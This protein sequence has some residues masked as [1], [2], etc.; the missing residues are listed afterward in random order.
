MG[1][2]REG[3][4]VTGERSRA[5]GMEWPKETLLERATILKTQLHEAGQLSARR[6]PAVQAAWGQLLCA[7]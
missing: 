3:G 2:G 1:V 4:I 6:E 5:V 7:V